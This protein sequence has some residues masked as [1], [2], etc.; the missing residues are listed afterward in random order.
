[1]C[2]ILES[3][4]KL[5]R[6]KEEIGVVLTLPGL[7]QYELRVKPQTTVFSLLAYTNVDLKDEQ[8]RQS[9]CYGVIIDI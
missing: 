7:L 9:R 2:K 6:K 5:T 1:M 3:I 4:L 8:E